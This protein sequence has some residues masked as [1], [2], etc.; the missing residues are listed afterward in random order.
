M[1]EAINLANFDEKFMREFYEAALQIAE[2][3]IQEGEAYLRDNPPSRKLL[4]RIATGGGFSGLFLWDSAFCC[5]WA[6]HEPKRFPITTTLDNFYLLQ[7][8]DGYIC[9]EFQADGKPYWSRKHPVSFNPPILSWAELELF[10]HGVTDVERLKKVFPHLK[11]H[12]DFCW[13][14]YRRSEDGLFFG[15]ALG[16]GMDNL[17]RQPIGCDFDIHGGIDIKLEHVLADNKRIWEMLKTRTLYCWNRQMG[18]IDYSSQM[19]FNAANLAK[20]AAAIGAEDEA[21]RLRD[22][23]AE[24]K[25]II[26]EQCYDPERGFY[27]DCYKGEVIPRY[28][29]GAFWALLSG[30]VPAERVE[31]VCRVICDEKIFNR[32]IPFP[33]LAACEKKY[34]PENGYWLGSSWPP[35]TYVGIRGLQAMGRGDLALDFARRY[36][37]ANA[38]LFRVSGTVWENISPEQCRQPKGHSGSSFCGW[39]ALAPVAIYK[40]FLQK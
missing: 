24:M 18:W 3:K 40:E 35:T 36:Y 29:A 20:I 26:N 12:F 6:K 1:S 34:D 5:I 4:P 10:E 31:A 7:D 21:I 15:D 30:I 37:N 28:H 22:K 16:S 32:P 2:K 14:N 9:R 33:S 39:G 8:E 25:Q 17:P 27:F 11:K 13:R 23:F 19:A 38:E